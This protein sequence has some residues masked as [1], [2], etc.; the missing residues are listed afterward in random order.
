MLYVNTI[1]SCVHTESFY[2]F[3]LPGNRYQT[4]EGS[5]G[6]NDDEDGDSD[7]FIQSKGTM[8][9]W[10]YIL[11]DLCSGKRIYKGRCFVALSALMIPYKPWFVPK[12]TVCYSYIEMISY[13][14]MS[15]NRC[16]FDVTFWCNLNFLFI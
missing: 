14:Y 9:D 6:V 13:M 7:E 3:L 1:I 5:G 11:V 10:K 12:S 8:N 16:A 2:E 4:D 15:F